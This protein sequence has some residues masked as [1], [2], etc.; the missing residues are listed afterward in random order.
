MGFGPKHDDRIYLAE[1]TNE[2]TA[3]RVA[4]I[5]LAVGEPH[6]ILTIGQGHSQDKKSQWSSFLHVLFK[7]TQETRRF[8]RSKVGAAAAQ[9]TINGNWN[10]SEKSMRKVYNF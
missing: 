8:P 3:R 6:E 2:P 4:H 5:R 9:E 1:K 7:T 10:Q